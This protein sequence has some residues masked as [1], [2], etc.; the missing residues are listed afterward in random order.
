MG[1]AIPGGGGLG[2]G[3][4]GSRAICALVSDN[5][6]LELRATGDRKWGRMVKGLE[7]QARECECQPRPATEEG[8]KQRWLITH[9]Y[10]HTH[11]HT[12]IQ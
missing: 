6:P 3:Y 11:A 8:V 9:T 7:C 1:R 12:H 5:V 10:T 4:E 2:G